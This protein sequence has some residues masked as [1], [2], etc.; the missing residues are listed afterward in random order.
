MLTM[1]KFTYDS[2]KSKSTFRKHG[3]TFKQAELLWNRDYPLLIEEDNR[4]E[5]GERRYKATG[6]LPNL[7]RIVVIYTKRG[8]TVRIISARQAETY[9]RENYYDQSGFTP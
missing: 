5:Y 7:I 1:P 4:V 3:I 9:E 2:A 8:G 6:L